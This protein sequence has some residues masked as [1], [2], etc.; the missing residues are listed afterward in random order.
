[1]QID[2]EEVCD[3]A[4]EMVQAS[5]VP[6]PLDDIKKQLVMLAMMVVKPA[7]E[8][9][10]DMT[11]RINAVSNQL[12]TYPADIVIGAISKVASESTFWPAYAEFNKHIVWRLTRRNKL[13]DTLLRK[14]VEFMQAE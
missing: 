9:G 8:G 12:A 6:L 5:L 2:S 10:K 14:K 3:K 13:L 11:A 4:I 1:M 7:G